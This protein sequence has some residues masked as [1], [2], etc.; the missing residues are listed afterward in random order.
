MKQIPNILSSIRL[1]LVGVFIWLF[2]K[3]QYLWCMIVYAAAFGTDV[4]DGWLARRNNW[5]TNVGKVLDPLADKLMRITLLS[6]FYAAHEIPLYILLI[7]VIKEVL[8]IVIGSVLYTKKVVVYADWFGKLATGLFC[9]AIMLTFI[10]LI[11][12]VLNIHLY[13]YWLA[14]AVAVASFFHYGMKTFIRK[15]G[16]GR[17]E[18]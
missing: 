17:I 7:I 1:L 16:N 9:C 12:G 8:M 13:V 4:L 5:I 2:V 6:C 11:W 15:K 14:I 3:Q 18:E 10:H